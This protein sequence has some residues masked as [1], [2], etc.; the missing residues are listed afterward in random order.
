MP[1]QGDCRWTSRRRAHGLTL[2][3]TVAVLFA[4]ALGAAAQSDAASTLV[5][6]NESDPASRS[7]A[8]YYA[9]RRG[10]AASSVL[11][12]KAPVDEEI[13][14][15]TFDARIRQPL[16]AA[17][18]RMQKPPKY[19]VVCQGVPLKIRGAGD[20]RQTDAA[21]VDS[22]LAALKLEHSMRRPIRLNGATPNPYFRSKTSS[23]PIFL[24]GRLAGFAFADV[25]ALVDRSLG[26]RAEDAA[27][28]RI[29][30]DMSEASVD[31]DGNLWLLRAARLL[32]G[33]RV[34]LDESPGVVE[35]VADVIAYA[36][37]GSNDSSRRR[38]LHGKRDL[39]LK[40]LPG[41]IAAEYVSTNARTLREPPPQWRFGDWSE[42]TSYFAGSPQSLAGDLVRAGVTGVS[43]HVYEPF[44]NQTAR[45]DVLIPA[46]LNERATLGEAFW[47]SI[48]S[49]SWMTM[50]IGDPL[51]RPR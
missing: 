39:G 38:Q 16:L 41:A 19:L 15:K 50:V 22:E 31:S 47:R 10:I 51:C 4:T 33:G 7:I 12:L 34:L 5:L 18:Q 3:F 43:G 44:L 30:L 27:R 35:G 49:V 13:D 17:L 1:H 42:V 14:R 37:W 24:V 26:A 46:Y 6:V 28:G 45:P 29:V 9:R 40:F 20:R 2:G 36:G 32:A 48:P 25:K 21:A 11:R 23:P 8:E